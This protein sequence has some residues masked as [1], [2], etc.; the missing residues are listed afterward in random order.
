MNK[1]TKAANKNFKQVLSVFGLF[2]NI[3][4]DARPKNAF[5]GGS[6]KKG[7]KVGYERR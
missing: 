1:K 4:I 2:G 3:A 5:R 7:G 6:T